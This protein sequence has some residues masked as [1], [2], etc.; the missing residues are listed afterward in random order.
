MDPSSQCNELSVKPTLTLW[1][2][3]MFESDAPLF[4]QVTLFVYYVKLYVATTNP[5]PINNRQHICFVNI[6][7]E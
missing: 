3:V 6:S 7:K 1:C 4:S 2:V 5:H